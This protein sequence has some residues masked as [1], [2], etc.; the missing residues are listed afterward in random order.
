[1]LCLSIRAWENHRIPVVLQQFEVIV[2]KA[3]FPFQVGVLL[4]KSI[5]PS[6]CCV[7]IKWKPEERSQPLP[8]RFVGYVGSTPPTRNRVEQSPPGHRE[9][10]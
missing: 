8:V 2:K 5:L 7:E 3:A 6:K 4:F 1:M 10:L 9:F